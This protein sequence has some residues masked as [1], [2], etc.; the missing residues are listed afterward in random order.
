MVSFIACMFYV[1]GM[2][3]AHK[4]A[5]DNGLKGF[6]VFANVVFWPSELG[7]HLSEI[8]TKPLR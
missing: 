8:V 7:Y 1:G 6:D 3:A 5:K 2:F 4:N